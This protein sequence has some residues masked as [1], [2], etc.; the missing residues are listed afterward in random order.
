VRKA[1]NLTTI[2]CRCHEIWEPE[3]PGTLGPVQ[4]CNG[5]ALPFFYYNVLPSAV[6]TRVRHID[7]IRNALYAELSNFVIALQ[8]LIQIYAFWFIY[9]YIYV[10]IYI[11]I[12]TYIE[13]ERERERERQID[14]MNSFYDI[15]GIV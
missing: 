13:R 3:L 15:S 2:L 6:G 5:T 10:Y 11:Y 8:A 14:Y 12:Y 1:D 9:I 4:A 7:C